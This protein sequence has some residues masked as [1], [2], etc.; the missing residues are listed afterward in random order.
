MIEHNYHNMEKKKENECR[1][2]NHCS[3]VNI[4]HLKEYSIKSNTNGKKWFLSFVSPHSKRLIAA[5]FSHSLFFHWLGSLLQFQNCFK[6][7]WLDSLFFSWHFW[8]P[9][10]VQRKMFGAFPFLQNCLTFRAHAGI[11]FYISWCQKEVNVI[12]RNKMEVASITIGSL[13]C[14]SSHALIQSTEP[15]TFDYGMSPSRR[16]IYLRTYNF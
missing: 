16:K 3:R 1:L 6:C 2:R 14:I 11:I 10:H 9:F 15:V 13:F 4:Y 12:W 5:Y 8:T 7:C